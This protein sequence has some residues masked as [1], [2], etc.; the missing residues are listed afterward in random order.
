MPKTDGRSIEQGRVERWYSMILWKKV[1]S[2]EVIV[3]SMT[4]GA[5]PSFSAAE[6]R[7]G[8]DVHEFLAHFAL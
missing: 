3:S 5:G 2:F 7:D 6:I 4:L 8:R 1:P